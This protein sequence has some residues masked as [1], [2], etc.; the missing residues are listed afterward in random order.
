[1]PWV[2]LTLGHGL[3]LPFKRFQSARF[4]DNHEINS[5][6]NLSYVLVNAKSK[7]L[8]WLDLPLFYSVSHKNVTFRP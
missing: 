8:S 1:M 6:I 7:P 3:N 5:N 4:H 2:H